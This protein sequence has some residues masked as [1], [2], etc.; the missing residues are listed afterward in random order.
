MVIVHSSFVTFTR[1]YTCWNH[2]QPGLNWISK[3]VNWTSSVVLFTSWFE[4]SFSPG[5]TPQ[6]LRMLCGQWN[7]DWTHDKSDIAQPWKQRSADLMH[8]IVVVIHWT[9][10]NLSIT[11]S[12]TQNNLKLGSDFGLFYLRGGLIILSLRGS[13]RGSSLAFYGFLGGCYSCII[14]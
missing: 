14:V 1:G 3:A 5:Q 13:P 7:T 8:S 12:P 4:I 6:R 2:Q 10:L 11:K 9:Y